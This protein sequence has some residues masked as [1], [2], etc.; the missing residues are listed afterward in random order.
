MFYCWAEDPKEA[1]TH[2]GVF[3]MNADWDMVN[4]FSR[5][6]GGI[7]QDPKVYCL[8]PPKQD[9]RGCPIG[10]CPNPDIDGPLVRIA[11]EFSFLP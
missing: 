5:R 1:P 9:P 10:I 4:N 11:R 6:A 8:D 2:E 7:S 3:P